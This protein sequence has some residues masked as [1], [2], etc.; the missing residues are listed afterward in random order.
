VQ[1]TERSPRDPRQA[2]ALFGERE[3][4]RRLEARGM[5]LLARR[6]RTREGE[7][8][9][10]FED[11]DAVVFVEVKTRTGLTGGRPAEAVTPRKQRRLART[12]EAFLQRRGWL[13]RRVR[14]DVVEVLAVPGRAPRI[15]HIR[16]AFRPAAGG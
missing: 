3:A 1:R 12:A 10:V 16:D 2:L 8:D 7:I 14:F 4:E 9:L 6:F 11:A 5:G 13:E 15:R